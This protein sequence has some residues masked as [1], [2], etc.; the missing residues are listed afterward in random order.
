MLQSKT[1][2]KYDTYKDSG[3]EWIGEI[4]AH[5]YVDKFS[6]VFKKITD[7]VASGSFADIDANV[8]YLDEPD[9]AML[10]RTADLSG[11]KDKRVYIDEHAY[12][13]L[14]NSNLFGGE[15][16]LSNIGSVGNVYIYE[17]MYE[18]SSLAPNA[19]MLDGS[20]NNKFMYYWLLSP[21]TNEELKKLG[22]NAVQLKFN[23]TQLR[24]FKALCPPK[25][26]QQQ[27][28]EYLDKK[29]GEID[30]VVETEKSVI[31]KLKEYKQSIIT[32]A[33]TKGLDK[34][35][36]LK[37]SG[38]EYLGNIPNN[39]NIKRLRYLAT[40]QN[41][42]SKGGEFFGEGAPFV[43]YGDVY[44][45]NV[46]PETVSGL[47]MVTD[48]EKENYSV[49]ENDIFFTRTSETI[50]EIA[51]TCVC[52]KTIPDATF[53][54]FL[55]RVRPYTD[56]LLVDFSKYYFASEIHRKFFVKE[57]NLVIRASLSQELLK[58]LPVLI[59]PKEEQ[60]QIAEYLDKKCSEI[61]KAIAD[62]EQVIEKFTEYKK[63]LIYEC[64]TGK[65]KVV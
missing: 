6:R 30:R 53:A 4:P 27:I 35:I 26:E 9:Y 38:I 3:I 47:C 12:N 37:Y 16:I 50:E 18:K 62:K 14:S 39:W 29:C 51:I 22:G 46:L 42:I 65:R 57:M 25:Q 8:H 33:V 58:K 19:I 61:D 54:G 64:V 31:E 45:N 36:S 11:T 44:N 21:L 41:G 1:V 52:K 5:W 23:K 60:R 15:L 2:K 59:P 32:E 10:V 63:S 34:S 24:Q 7:Y 55:I 43:S 48:A 40:C 56:E 17:P 20:T 28:A 13:Y 49:R